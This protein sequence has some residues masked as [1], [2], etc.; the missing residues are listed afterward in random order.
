[1]CYDYYGPMTD[2]VNRA[3]CAE[4]SEDAYLDEFEGEGYCQ[5]LPFVD[6]DTDHELLC[7][8]CL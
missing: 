1:M 3:F 8:Q 5:L 2:W 4:C 7:D 6:C